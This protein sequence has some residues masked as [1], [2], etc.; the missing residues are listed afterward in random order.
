MILRRQSEDRVGPAERSRS[1][2]R[3]GTPWRIKVLARAGLVGR[4][5]FVRAGFV[6]AG[7]VRAGFVRAGFV[8]AGF[9]RA[10]FVRTSTGVA[11]MTEADL[12]TCGQG[13]GVEAAIGRGGA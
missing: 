7:F 2:K 8:R 3:F 6:R 12:G 10:D 4:A 13:R 9:V 1:S 5:G 11:A